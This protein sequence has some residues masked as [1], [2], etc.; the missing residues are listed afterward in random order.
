MRSMPDINPKVLYQTYQADQKTGPL[1]RPL[2]YAR[3]LAIAVAIVGA[4]PTA[5]NLYYSY[6]DGIP[7]NEVSHRLQ[8]YD[9]WVKNFE[10]PVNYHTVTTGGAQG[11]TIDVGACPKTGDIALR[12]TTAS[13]KSSYEWISYAQLEQEFKSLALLSIG[14]TPAQAEE[15]PGSPAPLVQQLA[16]A[17]AAPPGSY[18]V[19]CEAMEQPGKI[20]RI[21]SE[22][23]KC[24][25]VH[26][27]AMQ[28]RA[29]KREEVPCN[30]QC[31][32]GRG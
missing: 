2:F 25:R 17:P 6:K 1:H 27:S 28:G 14:I 32:P 22:G 26:I 24:F 11:T 30:T 20:V 5:R 9:I 3:L 31:I 16:Q 23:G 13:G 21:F 8:Q 15:A 18:Q 10:C 12:L 29:E 19:H 7:L 4:A